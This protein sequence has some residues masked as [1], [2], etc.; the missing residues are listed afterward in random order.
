MT[1]PTEAGRA[2][3]TAGLFSPTE[4]SAKP[5]DPAVAKSR[6]LGTRPIGFPGKPGTKTGVLPA[7]MTGESVTRANTE[8]AAPATGSAAL[9]KAKGQF[10]LADQLGRQLTFKEMPVELRSEAVRKQMLG[11]EVVLRGHSG[12][13]AIMVNARLYTSQP[14]FARLLYSGKTAKN[15]NATTRAGDMVL[16]E[17]AATAT[18]L[19]NLDKVTF[20]ATG[21]ALEDSVSS[22][23]GF[24][25]AYA[26]DNAQPVLKEGERLVYE[27]KRIQA[28]GQPIDYSLD[29]N[30][31]RDAD[32]KI[33]VEFDPDRHFV[34]EGPQS[35]RSVFLHAMLHKFR[36][37]W[38]AAESP[39]E[40]FKQ[41]LDEAE[42]LTPR[43][44][45]GMLAHLVRHAPREGLRNDALKRAEDFVDRSNPDAARL[46]L[47]MDHKE[48]S[49]R[50]DGRI[51][52]LECLK[53]TGEALAHPSYPMRNSNV[54]GWGMRLKQRLDEVLDRDEPTLRPGEPP[55]SA[56]TDVLDTLCRST[57]TDMRKGDP[58]GKFELWNSFR[59]TYR[60][61]APPADRRPLNASYLEAGFTGHPLIRMLGEIRGRNSAAEATAFP[62]AY[63]D[64]AG[65]V[66]GQSGRDK[67]CSLVS[68]FELSWRFPDAQKHRELNKVLAD[69]ELAAASEELA[70]ADR[71]AVHR[72]L[73]EQ[74]DTFEDDS[75]YYEPISQLARMFERP[76]APPSEA[77]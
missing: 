5:Q 1:S 4:S 65:Q 30:A 64:I 52:A 18:A 57:S 7:Q 28:H 6:S 46:R 47:P 13:T 75:E 21:D 41:F 37:E 55:L 58:A 38:S 8:F 77:G 68:M 45:V 69:F 25:K 61:M 16:P 60:R 19:G 2:D 14:E 22:E 73:T 9:Q 71:D 43:E 49:E 39:D 59:D 33:V 40:A 20:V 3:P 76:S 48:L 35:G 17:I 63:R 34:L 70:P 67:L 62:A 56:R 42:L 74:L 72:L 29:K 32:G 26:L 27:F 66:E 36:R 15:L 12:G 23:F 50:R 54:A 31:Q 11:D 53:E 24:S 51:L 10:D 44:Q